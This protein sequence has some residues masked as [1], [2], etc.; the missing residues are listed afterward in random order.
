[1]Y[2]LLDFLYIYITYLVSLLRTPY[3]YV[4]GQEGVDGEVGGGNMVVRG[5]S[6]M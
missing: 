1:M 4:R 2:N 5:V 6:Y 3:Y